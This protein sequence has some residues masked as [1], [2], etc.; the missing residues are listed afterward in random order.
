MLRTSCLL[1]TSLLLAAC[2]APQ[3]MDPGRRQAY[4]ECDY[5]AKKATASQ[6]SS[7]SRV[8][9][10]AEVMRACMRLKGY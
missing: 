10:G 4:L 1:L 8:V 2:A 5:E 3:P 9:E 6:L 7:A